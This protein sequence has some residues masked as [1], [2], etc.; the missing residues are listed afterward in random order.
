MKPWIF[1]SL[2][3]LLSLHGTMVSVA[4]GRFDHR[5]ADEVDR[6]EN[7]GREAVIDELSYQ[8]PIRLKQ[9]WQKAKTGFRASGGSLDVNRFHYVEDIK[10]K[11]E[12]ENLFA[13]FRQEIEQTKVEE[14]RD[15]RL[16]FGYRGDHKFGAAILS[17]GDTYKKWADVG[18]AIDYQAEDKG[19]LE[20]YYFDVDYYYNSK[21]SEEGDR[22]ERLPWSAGVKAD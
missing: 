15:R 5:D 20:I 22:Y 14:I 7:F 1:F 4:F 6:E 17:D 8:F 18:L 16:A 9:S 11:V 2:L 13:Y 3:F 19:S 21:E 12:S 10:L